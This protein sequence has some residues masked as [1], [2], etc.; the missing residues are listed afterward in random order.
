MNKLAFANCFLCIILWFSALIITLITGEIMNDF[1]G[2][3]L[4][5]LPLLAM[6]CAAASVMDTKLEKDI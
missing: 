1:I 2:L 3:G 6:A 4:V 5:L